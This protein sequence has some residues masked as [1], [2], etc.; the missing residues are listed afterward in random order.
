MQTKNIWFECAHTDVLKTVCRIR[1]GNGTLQT[2]VFYFIL[3]FLAENT[4]THTDDFVAT[5][6]GP[7]FKQS[8]KLTERWYRE[9]KNVG[10]PKKRVALKM[11]TWLAPNLNAVHLVGLNMMTTADFV[12][13]N[14]SSIPIHK[15]TLRHDVRKVYNN[16]E[17]IFPRKKILIF[18]DRLRFTNILILIQ[19]SS[20][21]IQIGII[22]DL[23]LWYGLLRIKNHLNLIFFAIF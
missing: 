8:A 20:P 1:W 12:W 4:W 13:I 23:R 15:L 5:Q 3:I 21:T 14:F 2:N 19:D 6:E 10:I 16:L 9:E 11:A 18:H 22:S 7:V 17:I